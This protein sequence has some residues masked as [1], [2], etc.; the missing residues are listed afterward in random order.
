MGRSWSMILRCECPSIK[1][2]LWI[3]MMVLGAAAPASLSAEGVREFTDTEGRKIQA[4]LIKL[5]GNCRDPAFRGRK[6]L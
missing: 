2:A 4:E 6:D 5:D 3:L 1:A